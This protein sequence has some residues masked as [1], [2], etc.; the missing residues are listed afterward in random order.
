MEAQAPRRRELQAVRS[1]ARVAKPFGALSLSLAGRWRGLGRQLGYNG[2][3]GIKSVPRVSMGKVG[4][5]VQCQTR[6]FRGSTSRVRKATS[7]AVSSK[8]L[9]ITPEALDSAG[10]NNTFYGTG[11][12]GIF[13]NNTDRLSERFCRGK[14]TQKGR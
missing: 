6:S 14:T 10:R 5:L 8:T 7:T 12:R 2:L 9:T 13:R 4:E 11:F 1:L 3:Q